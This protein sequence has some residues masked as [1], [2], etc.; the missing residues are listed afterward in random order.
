MLAAKGTKDRKRGRDRGALL[1]ALLLLAALACVSS[2]SCPEQPE[3]A[4][5][6]GGEVAG[7]RRF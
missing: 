1:A 7:A 6:Q 3:S 4:A 5:A 2:V